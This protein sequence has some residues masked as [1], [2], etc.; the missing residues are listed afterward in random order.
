MTKVRLNKFLASAGVASRRK[1]DEIIFSGSVTV[2]GRVA[3]GPFVLVDPEDKVQV[4]GTSVHLTK[5]VYFMVHKAIGYLCSSEKKFP[6]TKL[7]I[8][9]FAH[10]PYRVFTVGR[11]DKETSGLILVTNDGEFAN[12]I[13][14]PSSGITKEY[15]LKVS[16]D[17]SAKDLGKL[18]EGTFIDGKHV[19]PVS[20]TK[21]RRGTVKIVVSEG[22][23]HE[24]RLFADAAGFPILELKRIRIG[25]L[26]LGG[27]RYGEY[28]EL[29]DAE[30]GT[31][32]KLSD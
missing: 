23:K 24:I 3:E 19:R 7:V 9:L 32:M 29:T 15:L 21:I 27:L 26:V 20:V 6:G 17:V 28:R 22:K 16:R 12:K 2:N 30:L 11:L 13:I 4:G 25:S 18:M 5:K 14:H 10:L 31:Y 1:C 8:D